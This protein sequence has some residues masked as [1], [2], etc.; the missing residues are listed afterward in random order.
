M[1][2]GSREKAAAK[3]AGGQKLAEK[4]DTRAERPGEDMP[5][6]KGDDKEQGK[7]VVAPEKR[8]EGRDQVMLELEV[9]RVD[10]ETH[11]VYF[12]L[13]ENPDYQSGGHQFANRIMVN[14]DG[15]KKWWSSYPGTAYT[16][17][18]QGVEKPTKAALDP[19]GKGRL[20]AYHFGP[21]DSVKVKTFVWLKRKEPGL[22]ELRANVPCKVSLPGAGSFETSNDGKEFKPHA[23]QKAG[24]SSEI[25]LTAAELGNGTLWLRY[26]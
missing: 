16:W 13:P 9:T 4:E 11:L 17:T 26:K 3:Q 5:A 6:E 1:G 21:G 25:K 19:D 22:F 7:A 14:E 12:R 24:P 10:P 20:N 2:N 23:S 8:L 18:L 15:S